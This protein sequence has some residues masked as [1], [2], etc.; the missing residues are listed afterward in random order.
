MSKDI[1]NKMIE[2]EDK[3]VFIYAIPA[4]G[5]R[6]PVAAMKIKASDL[7]IQL[8]LDDSKAMNPQMKISNYENVHVFAVISNLGT[9]G[10]KT[11]DFKGQLDNLAVSTTDT[12]NIIIDTIVP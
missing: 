6:I 9:P 7:P 1:E 2:S 5:A 10:I 11:G 8:T 4:E 12:V 3:T